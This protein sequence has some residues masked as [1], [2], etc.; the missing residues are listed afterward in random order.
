MKFR[1]LACLSAWI[2]CVGPLLGQNQDGPEWQ[3]ADESVP[4][5]TML[6]GWER[7]DA[8]VRMEKGNDPDPNAFVIVEQVPEPLNMEE[9]RA[10][11]GYPPMAM[12]A[13]IE[14]RVILRVLVDTSG[15]Y[16]KHLVLRE[17]HPILLKAVEK[18]ISKLKF[19]PAIQDQRAIPCWTTIPFEF[20]L[21]KDDGV[22]VGYGFGELGGEVSTLEEVDEPNPEDFVLVDV[23]PSPLNM[24][25]VKGL[26]GYPEAAKKEGIEGKVVVRILVGSNGNYVKHINIREVHP[27]LIEAVE[28]HL[29]KLKY[30]PGEQRGKA[31]PVWVT[32]PFDFRAFP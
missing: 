12:E 27:L 31:I 11:I 21:E 25:E 8:E 15:N 14:G 3:R 6:V 13:E 26:I 22:E 4:P 18:H 19:K 28:A 17:V 2:L 20:K 1:F 7:I 30:T 32:I 10:L 23:A 9:V 29:P 5:D 16:K 24:D